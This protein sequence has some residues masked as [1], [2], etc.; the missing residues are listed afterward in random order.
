VEWSGGDQCH[1]KNDPLWK[2]DNVHRLIKHRSKLTEAEMK[3]ARAS[4]NRKFYTKKVDTYKKFKDDLQ[5]KLNAQQLS[6]EEYDRLVREERKKVNVGWYGT[7]RQGEDA[8]RDAQEALASA[9]ASGNQIDI[10]AAVFGLVRGMEATPS[11]ELELDG[12]NRPV[13]ADVDIITIPTWDK[14]NHS[15]FLVLLSLFLPMA[16]WSDDPISTRNVHQVQLLLSK[17]KKFADTNTIGPYFP[18]AEKERISKMF[19]VA[20]DEAKKFWKHA[21]PEERDVFKHDWEAQRE[22]VQR[23]FLTISKKYPPVVFHRLLQN[24]YEHRDLE[25]DR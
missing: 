24:A 4:Y 15:D 1:P 18:D 21:G 5:T 6:R 7:V 25:G 9:Q 20:W 17:D 16:L 22:R 2:D 8:L 23:T 19:N 14:P 13:R 3:E 12:E 11:G 10:E